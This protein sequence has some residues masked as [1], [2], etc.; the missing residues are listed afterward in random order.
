MSEKSKRNL[1][2]ASVA[3]FNEDGLL[4]FGKRGH[5]K[6][7]CLPGGKFE[8][9]EPPSQ[10]AIRELFEETGLTPKL[11]LEFLGDMEVPK[12]GVHVFSFKT[13]VISE[14]D[15]S[16]DPDGEF[17]E[18]QW[19][20]PKNLP[21]EILDN[22]HNKQDVTLQLLGLQE[23]T[24]NKSSGEYW[25]GDGIRI[26]T[27]NNPKR[28]I[29]DEAYIEKVKELNKSEGQICLVDVN[30]ISGHN[31]PVNKERLK[32][33]RRMAKAGDELP[34]L[35]IRYDGDGLHL[36]DG[37]HRQEIYKELG[38]QYAKAVL[39]TGDDIKK[40]A[41]LAALAA[42]GIITGGALQ[43]DKPKSAVHSI[44][45]GAG[46]KTW[47]PEGLHE[48]LY[49]IAHLESTFGKRLLHQPHSKGE[50][51]TAF[52]AL[53]F[54]PSTAHEEYKKSK[55]LQS[56]YPGLLDPAEFMGAFKKDPKFY[57]MLA[58][59]HFTR[60]KVR[61]GG[62]AEEA[63]R[64]WRY[65]SNAVINK[66]PEATEDKE[67]YVAKY[68]DLKKSE[69]EKTSLTPESTANIMRPHQ[70][71]GWESFDR[72]ETYEPKPGVYHHVY[73]KD[74]SDKYRSVLHSLSY[75]TNPL[76]EGFAT[77]AS[78]LQPSGDKNAWF[79]KFDNNPWGEGDST[80]V[81]VHGE[82][83]SHGPKGSGTLLYE[84]M[85]KIHGRMA[86]DYST[87]VGANKVWEKIVSNPEFK[88]KL[89]YDQHHRHWAEYNGP[90][91][92]PISVIEGDGRS[93]EQLITE[94]KHNYKFDIKQYPDDYTEAK[95]KLGDED[96]G[97]LG[98]HLDHEK[99]QLYSLPPYFATKG[100]SGGSYARFQHQDKGVI[101]LA[102]KQLENHFGYKYAGDLP[103]E[104]AEAKLAAKK[105][106]VK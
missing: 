25:L 90:K 46:V 65:G 100:L 24:L 85:L 55:V 82:T 14:P 64:A 23:K 29:W 51:H 42:L 37:N 95:I 77:S 70:A 33:Y 11:H 50:Y 71:S 69:L 22:L 79:G 99:K 2:V 49:P 40:G 8:R 62:S 88:G 94:P 31:S 61:H 87:S 47:T 45:E 91:L 102:R 20:E 18:F 6:K 89:G 83:A 21:K 54:K 26:P 53:G 104:I 84:Q 103:S 86:S 1:F 66:K 19:V 97:Y 32:L 59:A 93:L 58:S 98:L 30:L 68:R 5:N 3:V 72:I 52:G 48:D 60:L 43:P 17:V 28:L 56:S 4:L 67:G 80:P 96:V 13:E 63:A 34:P 16:L 106:K 36:I 105:Q 41:G 57:N 73:Y 101:G 78:G 76:H 74:G 12:I 27:N 92:K 10:A 81:I 39:I 44:M 15:A 9:S 75:S 35:T 38:V 7:W